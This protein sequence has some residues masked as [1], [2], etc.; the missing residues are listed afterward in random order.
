MSIMK[1]KSLNF[2]YFVWFFLFSSKLLL[3]QEV[4]LPTSLERDGKINLYVYHTEQ[5]V[6]FD[7]LDEKGEWKESVYNQINNY[8]RSYADN[9]I[10]PIDK[11]L[12]ELADHLQDHFA[13]DTV[14]IISGYRSPAFNK[15]LKDTG[16]NVAEES[17]HTKGMA[18]DIHLDDIRES[19]LRDYLKT[20]GL[21]G[22]GY[23]GNKLMVHMDFGPV[24][25]WSDGEFFENLSVG[26]FNK[27]LPLRMT[28]QYFYY[29]QY[30]RIKIFSEKPPMTLVAQNLFVEHFLRGEWHKVTPVVFKL[31]GQEITFDLNLLNKLKPRFG[32]FRVVFS[33]GHYW[34]NSNEFYVKK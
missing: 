15:S 33:D 8:L 13:V 9:K 31:Q 12:I 7:Y 5:F 2:F 3:A 29:H 20:L 30:D 22:V 6:E 25:E 11:R 16:H 27:T 18:L 34:Q 19:D 21:G 26:V 23:Y 32:K 1:I 14:E 28:T 10:H 17:Y 24:R 4:R